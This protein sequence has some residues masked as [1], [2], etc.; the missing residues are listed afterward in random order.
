MDT[1]QTSPRAESKTCYQ[2]NFSTS[3][4]GAEIYTRFFSRAL[5]AKGWKTTLYINEKAD[6]W[7]G[8]DLHGIDLVPLKHKD[9]LPANLP[10]R[11]S[12]I[13]TH[14]PLSG[15][16]A[17]RLRQTHIL[18]GIVHHPIYGGN[19]EPYRSYQLLFPVSRHVIDTLET[20]G[21]HHYHPEPLYGVAD[22]NR[23]K[24]TRD[25]PLIATPIYDWDKRK[26]R[27]RLLRLV[28]PLFWAIR[29]T[30]HFERKEGLTLGIVSR[31][32]AAKQFP[33]LFEILSPVIRKFP[34][35]HLEIFGS[36]VG[37]AS[38]RKLRK[39]LAPIKHQVRFWG[40][41]TDLNKVYHSMDFLLA[42]LPEKEAMGLNILE[43]QFCGT[44]VLATNAKPFN[45]IVKD[46]KTGFLYTDPRQDGGL[47]FERLLTRLVK[48]PSAPNP[49]EESEFL[50]FFSFEAFSNRIDS[51]LCEALRESARPD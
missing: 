37:Y 49:L 27:D 32:A 45:E 15:Q 13:V 24:Q 41:Q 51:A 7:H 14:T 30:R 42:G 12:L 36:G 25:L 9:E 3:L 18:T 2:V 35:A 39:S 26:L 11:R 48:L 43:A 10:A 17:N 31:I 21:I 50:D 34:Q 33:A 8:M 4:G 22:L 46:G 6:F 1:S 19:G 20:A 44:P 28:Y 38:I 16:L 5:L 40:P 23:L 47:D 29:P